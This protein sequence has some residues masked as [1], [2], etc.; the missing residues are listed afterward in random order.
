MFADFRARPHLAELPYK[1]LFNLAALVRQRPLEAERIDGIFDGIVRLFSLHCASPDTVML[2]T[3]TRIRL[4]KRKDKAYKLSDGGGM[5]LLI[6][7]DGARYWR[8]D[9]RFAGKRRTLALGVYPTVTL[10]SA[11]MRRED[12]RR[13]LAEGIDPNVVKKEIKL[14]AKLASENTFEIIARE[15]HSKQQKRLADRYCALLLARLEGDI[16]PQIGSRP[17]GEISAPELLD[18]LRKVENRGAVETA[19]RLRQTCGQVFRYAIATRRAKDDPTA[20]LRGAISAPRRSRGHKAMPLNEI[21]NFL[22]VL[23]GYDGDLRT[24]LALRLIVLTFARTTEI[25]AAKWSEFEKLDNESQALWRIPAERMKMKREH[26]VPLAPQALAVLRELRT[27][28]GSCATPYLFPSASREGHMSNNTMLY[29]MYRMGYHGRATIHGF[30]AMAST[31]LNEMGFRPDVIERQLAHEE[32]NAVRAAYNR[33]EYLAERR[34]MMSHWAD[35]LDA[36]AEGNI[37]SLQARTIA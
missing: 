26:I 36:L 12:A 15:W 1:N 30:R 5:Y 7:P 18:V 10:A 13:L 35:Y 21:P 31:A 37:V 2:L 20:A 6:T 16:F 11:R 34:A 33:A 27:L 32:Q 14:D 19:R 9:Y 25:R 29:A 3:D 8:L 17:I 28:A 4:T 24:R 23:A 22:R